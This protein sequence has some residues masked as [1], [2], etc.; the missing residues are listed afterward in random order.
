MKLL[1]PRKQLVAYLWFW[2][3]HVIK[4][5][6]LLGREDAHMSSLS[7]LM[8]VCA[9]YSR[10]CDRCVI[11]PSLSPTLCL[12]LHLPHTRHRIDGYVHPSS[13]F[14]PTPT[15]QKSTT[16]ADESHDTIRPLPPHWASV[17]VTRQQLNIC[18]R[19]INQYEDSALQNMMV[20]IFLVDAG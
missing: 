10:R 20:W 19:I 12:I 2:F 1:Q 17:S 14:P 6:S 13:P 4:L 18:P 7:S 9:R 15:S 8:C 11:F 16:P 3:P 5:K